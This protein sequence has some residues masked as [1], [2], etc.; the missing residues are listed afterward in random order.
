MRWFAFLLICA[1]IYAQAE[2][3]A[4]II[5]NHKGASEED[6]PYIQRTIAYTV[7]AMEDAFAAAGVKTI[8]QVS[9]NEPAG[10]S[11]ESAQAACRDAGVRWGLTVYTVFKDGRFSWRFGV[12]DGEDGLFRGEDDFVVF[13]Y[14]GLSARNAIEQSALQLVTR[15]QKSFD[16]QDFKGI[17][18]VPIGQRFISSQEGVM[19]YYGDETGFFMGR[20][21]SGS[22]AAPL[23]LFEEGAPVYGT[24]A[25]AGFWT[26]TFI[27]PEG[28]T[29]KP[30]RLPALQRAARHTIGFLTEIRGLEQYGIDMEYRYAFLP[31]RMFFK[32]DL[33]LWMDPLFYESSFIAPELK[34]GAGLYLLAKR[35]LPV[36]FVAGAGASVFFPQNNRDSAS[37]KNPVQVYFD[38]LW[39]GLEYHFSQVAITTEF[40]IPVLWDELGGKDW[41]FRAAA[42][43][44]WPYYVTIGIMLK[45]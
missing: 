3:S 14:V 2:E 4:V 17:F 20:I 21:N 34:F 40:R 12:Y 26:K 41:Y 36:R 24:L 8:A 10:I 22:L 35:D 5:V 42:K 44:S 28:I 31:D 19:V 25:K 13:L 23:L 11:Y 7:Q 43:E 37:A 27:L 38:P 30:V 29:D 32:F 18:A 33:V 39:L 1:G 9:N 6:T 16:V 45:W 15:W